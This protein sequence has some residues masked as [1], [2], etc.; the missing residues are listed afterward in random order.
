MAVFGLSGLCGP[1]AAAGAF[2]AILY[3]RH[4]LGGMSGDISGYGITI[5]EICGAAVLLII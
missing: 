4:E 3:G 1:A 2:L 5:G